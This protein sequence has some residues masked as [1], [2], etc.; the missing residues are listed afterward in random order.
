MSIFGVTGTYAGS[1]GDFAVPLTVT[2]DSGATVTAMNGDTTLT[3]TSVDGHANFILTSGGTWQV[4]ARLGDLSTGTTV[5]VPTT[6]MAELKFPG[7]LIYYGIVTPLNM[8]SGSTYKTTVATSNPQLCNFCVTSSRSNVD[9]YSPELTQVIVENTIPYIPNFSAT[10]V[11]EYALL[12][13]VETGLQNLMSFM[14]IT[15]I[16]LK[17]NPLD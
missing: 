10:S 13:E 8:V 3:A 17:Q 6:L 7:Q 15:P 16:L 12:A 11:G 5:K 14:H 1:G 9:A 4:T 2:V